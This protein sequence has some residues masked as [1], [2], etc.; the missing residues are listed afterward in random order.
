[1]LKYRQVEMNARLKIILAV[2]TVLVAVAA[3]VVSVH[4]LN[5]AQE[6]NRISRESKLPIV[7]AISNL[8]Y[9]EE[10]S[11]STEKVS[12][13]NGGQPLK[14]FRCIPYEIIEIRCPSAGSTEQTYL[15][16]F[17]YFDFLS[18][19][20]TGNSQ[21]LLYTTFGKKNF[22]KYISISDAFMFTE[23]VERPSDLWL[24]Q[25]TVLSIEYFDQF[26]QYYQGYLVVTQRGSYEMETNEAWDMI[27]SAYD[28][29]ELAEGS[30]LNLDIDELDGAELWNW[31]EVEILEK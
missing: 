5:T 27:D 15:P 4:S 23:D 3:L 29:K 21:G 25:I 26:G 8:V 31:Y 28:N 17:G 10:G 11:L 16:L 14:N 22:S 19:E 2:L 12:V 6:A 9:D 18:E 20:Y 30:G 7:T 1:M 24:I 13:M